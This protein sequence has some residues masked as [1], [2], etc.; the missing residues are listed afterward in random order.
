MTMSV[1]PAPFDMLRCYQTRHLIATSIGLSVVIVLV[2]LIIPDVV[3]LGVGERGDVIVNGLEMDEGHQE[4]VLDPFD[5]GT[6]PAHR[7]H[8]VELHNGSP[9]TDRDDLADHAVVVAGLDAVGQSNPRANLDL[10][11]E[12]AGIASCDHIPATLDCSGDFVEPVVE[13]PI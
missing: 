13:V 3:G 4:L 9:V 11:H 5:R 6:T 10:S 7:G 1:T 12:A 2:V 8:L